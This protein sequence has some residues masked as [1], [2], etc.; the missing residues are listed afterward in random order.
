LIIFY[1]VDEAARR[2]TIREGNRA[3][4]NACEG[5]CEINFTDRGIK[6]NEEQQRDNYVATTNMTWDRSAGTLFTETALKDGQDVFQR[7]SF[8][9]ACK[10]SR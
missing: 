10:Q 7:A 9:G 1:K 3:W 2:I 8:K 5:K 6:L 4:R